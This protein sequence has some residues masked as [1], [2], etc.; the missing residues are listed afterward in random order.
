MAALNAYS[1]FF[2]SITKKAQSKYFNLLP[3]ILM[4][5]PPLKD[6]GDNDN[7]QSAFLALTELAEACPRM[8]RR[9]FSDLVKHPLT[10]AGLEQF[11]KDWAGTGQS[12]L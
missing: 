10:D 3:D 1:S 5:L 4:I 7:L 9:V 2:H 8:F 6:E 12:I 11:A